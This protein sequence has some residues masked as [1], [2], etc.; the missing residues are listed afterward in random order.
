MADQL[1]LLQ[2][3]R[4]ASLSGVKE[5]QLGAMTRAQFLHHGRAFNDGEILTVSLSAA[6]VCFLK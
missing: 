4:L 1:S 6:A 5:K 3:R 2:L